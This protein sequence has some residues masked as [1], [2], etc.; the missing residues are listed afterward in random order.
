MGKS[1]KESRHERSESKS[2]E[3]QEKRMKTE[4]EYKKSSSKSANKGYKGKC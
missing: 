1:Y 3:K 2:Y 4:V